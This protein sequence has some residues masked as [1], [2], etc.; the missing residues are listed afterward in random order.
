MW[1][2][3]IRLPTIRSKGVN[4]PGLSRKD[5]KMWA[6]AITGREI[7]Q[8]GSRSGSIFVLFPVKVAEGNPWPLAF[9]A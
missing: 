1:E 7:E 4:Y 3:L 9:I 5:L 2:L 8:L 6:Y